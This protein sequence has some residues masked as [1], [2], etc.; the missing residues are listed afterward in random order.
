MVLRL[1]FPHGDLGR[2]VGVTVGVSDREG[3]FG[4]DAATHITFD[5]ADGR[6]NDFQARDVEVDRAVAQAFAGR[7]RLEALELNRSGRYQ[8]ATARLDAVAKRIRGYAGSDPDL[9]RIASELDIEK[10]TMSAWMAPATMKEAHFQFS[11]MARSR[12]P[13]GKAQKGPGR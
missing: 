8:D 2:A 10:P 6:T 9:L 7:A 13:Q 3:A 1:N 4:A 5:Y 12:S 11:A